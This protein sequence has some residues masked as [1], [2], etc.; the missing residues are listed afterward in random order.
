ME[1]DDENIV[2]SLKTPSKNEAV[3]SDKDKQISIKDQNGNKIIMSESGIT[4][5]S[6]KD[7]NIEASQNLNLK[8]TQGVKIQSSP[9][10]IQVTGMNVKLTAD[11]QFSAEGSATAELK[12]GAQT[13]VKGAMVMIN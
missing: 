1:F 9:G 6:D 7:I 13:S 12:G 8:G 2:F 3:F 4:I 11:T 5:K 10:D